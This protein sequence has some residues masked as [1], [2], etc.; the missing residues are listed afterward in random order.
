MPVDSDTRRRLL[1]LVYDLLGDDEATELRSQIDASEELA[2]AYAEARSTSELLGEAAR[3]ESSKIA[4]A[5]P[6]EPSTPPVDAPRP[7]VRTRAGVD[8]R[9]SWTRG[10]NWTVGTAAGILLTILSFGWF[11]DRTQLADIAAGHVRLRVTG[12][13]QLQAGAE[14]EYWITTTTVTGEPIETKIRFALFTPDGTQ[15][16]MSHTE[17][18]GADGRLRVAVQADLTLVREAK[19]EVIA[20]EEEG[21]ERIDTRLA[22]DPIRYAT[23]LSL[24]KPL[25]QPG[26]T[27]YYR[28]LTLS[29]FDL[30]PGREMSIRFEI[31]DP[32]GA[33]VPGSTLEGVTGQ[34]VGSGAFVLPR[35]IAGGEYTLVAKSLDGAFPDGAFPNGAFPDEQATFFVR[36]YRLPRL[37][38]ELEFGRDSYAAGDTVTADFAA[39]RAEGGPAANA[40]LRL[41][42]IVD[43]E[44]VFED[45]AQTASD[46]TFRIEFTLPEE[47]ER[48]EGHLLVVVDDGGVLETI[49]KTIPLNLGKVQVTF[50]PEGGDLVAGMTNR[51]YFSARDPLG[52]PVHL[53]GQVVDALGWA[54]ANVETTHEGMGTFS[55]EPRP[56]EPYRLEIQSPAAAQSGPPLPEVS[57]TRQVVLNAGIGVF[58]AGAPLEFNVRA[59]K[60]DLPMVAAA[61]CRGVHVGQQT[62][63]TE[64]KANPVSIPLSDDVGGVIRLT[65]YD[66]QTHPPEPV[67][68]RLVY[69]RRPRRL[70]IVAQSQAPR[71][72]PGERVAVSLRVTDE[73]GEPVSAVLGAAVVDDALL[74]LADDNRAALRTHLVLT[75]E[76]QNPQDLEEADFY[77]SESQEADVALDLLLGT[78]GWRRFVERT[79]EELETEGRDDEQIAR[80]VAMGGE[81]DPPAMFDN[82]LELQTRYRESLD[83]YR[84]NRTRTLSALTTIAFFGGLGLVL[85][86]AM[87]SLLNIAS[88]PRLWA[89]AI[90]VATAC[91]VV[92]MILMNPERLNTVRLGDVAFAPFDMAPA[93]PRAS[94]PTAAAE[95]AEQMVEEEEEVRPGIDAAKEF[96]D[97]G[98][99]EE[100]PLPD[101]ALA[102]EPLAAAAELA[103]GAEPM[104]QEKIERRFDLDEDFDAVG[105]RFRAWRPVAKRPNAEAAFFDDQRRDIAAGLAFGEAGQVDKKAKGL[106]RDRFT[107]RQ[108]AHQ[109]RP[110][111]PGVRTDFTE[112]LFWH[113]L[114]MTDAEGLAHIEFDLSDSVTTFRVLVDGHA[115]DGR[116]G[117]GGGEIVSR[118]PFSLQPTLPLEVNAGDRIDLPVAITNDTAEMLPV[119]VTLQHGDL[120]RLQDD[121]R[122]TLGARQTLELGPRGR[123]RVYFPL[124]VIGRK[125]DC[126]LTF[127]GTAGPLADAIE[128]RL[129]V[130]PPGFP[131]N[132]SYGGQI[133]GRR[134]LVVRLPDDWVPGSLDVSLRVF[135]SML[136]DLQQGTESIFREP[137]GC[138]EQASTSNYPN[139]LTLSYMRENNLANPAIT[140]SAKELLAKGYEKLIGYES[141]QAGFEWFGG[142]PGHEALTAYGLME[143]RD[144]AGVYDVDQAMLDRTAAWLL[145]RRDGQGGFKRNPK[146]LDSFGGAPKEI[147]DA[148]ITWALS[149]SDQEGIE[150]EI[151]YVAG[152]GDSSDD[153]YLL[154]LAGAAAVNGGEKEAGNR[155][156]QKLARFQAED[157]HLE[158][159]AG[160]IT[161]S[162]GR[163]LEMET[164]AL[165][166]LAWLKLP[167]FTAQANRAVE[168]IMGNRQGAGGFG[169]TQATILALKALLKHTKANRREVH[170]GKLIVMRD[171]AVL[172]EQ[173]FAAGSHEA[174]ALD[175][176]EAHFTSG[177]NRIVI[178]LTG[179]NRMP[180]ALDVGYRSLQPGDDDACPL[181]LSTRLGAETVRSGD[182]VEL[183]AELVNTTGEG[184]PM[185]VAILGLPAGLEIR[186][187]Q[188]EELKKTGAID[189]YE[190]R[191]RELICYWRSLKPEQRIELKLDLIAAVPGRYTGPASR[192]YLYYTAEQKRWNEP[193]SIEIKREVP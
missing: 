185:T 68:E 112:T 77:L 95:L 38:K 86:V 141:P 143:F 182:S 93:S 81:A 152:L 146:A 132:V 60:A 190:T 123:D 135:P 4:L 111:P 85:L 55:F 172:L 162:G 157:G 46:G 127:R 116:I 176:L 40:H 191:S 129:T 80:L 158:G 28:S 165:A 75:T 100:M 56:G 34:S 12:P 20:G 67:A 150:A 115:P 131:K 119:T 36:R 84:T 134:E 21:Q 61:W 130:V 103:A 108:Y 101:A 37:K 106:E 26:E 90:A 2:R 147:T 13:A 187:D 89:P 49:A 44:K 7:K 126:Q 63:V 69:R 168:W 145:A 22:V 156:L 24:D 5:R 186:P 59:L 181:R 48:G 167:A 6:A 166:A 19:L 105:G 163:S 72:S 151:E 109:Y 31:L 136:A 53:T 25:Y 99:E 102:D 149:E 74:S 117:T 180:F 27:V 88:G 169:S 73:S 42:G 41:V 110:G 98:A 3:L 58:E 94:D 177:D 192:A 16:L 71:Y 154:A 92:G 29:R 174:I 9:G 35:Q 83:Q 51:V 23:H 148:Y 155:I 18:T 64:A 171:D 82:L 113:P 178:A 133:E 160:S 122:Q 184:Q 128:R 161:R 14:N 8:V 39:Q 91:L 175:G 30:A 79:L 66:Y 32:S 57:S 62:F 125:G 189:Y 139:V 11:F 33:V 52:E 78:Q 45:S 1:E 15:R 124:E 183:I 170:D 43:G 193:L 65:I 188:L 54:V 121:A 120:V 87:L 114:L 137:H 144:M 173:S 107:V 179:D 50:S 140:R 10:A 17:K 118:I 159:T 70:K 97:E 142:D 47:I 104:L 164:T 96:A 76:I 138:F 153:P